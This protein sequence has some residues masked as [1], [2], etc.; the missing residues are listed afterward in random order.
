[1]AKSYKL[2]DDNY[3]DA[4]A[5]NYKKFALN[6][7]LDVHK[8]TALPI[9]GVPNG[10]QVPLALSYSASVPIKISGKTYADNNTRVTGFCIVTDN[11]AINFEFGCITYS[12]NSS[13][14]GKLIY[15]YKHGGFGSEEWTFV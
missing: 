15:R 3:I 14:R 5:I 13:L 6:K 8:S 2:K 11:N 10:I 7:V 4:S 1:M 9:V 12:D